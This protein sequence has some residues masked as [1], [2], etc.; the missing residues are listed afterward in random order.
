MDSLSISVLCII[1]YA[2][3]TH[4]R[5]SNASRSSSQTKPQ[6]EKGFGYPQTYFGPPCQ[7]P[8]FVPISKDIAPSATYALPP[9]SV[10]EPDFLETCKT[11]VKKLADHLTPERIRAIVF[12]FKRMVDQALPMCVAPSAHP[13]TPATSS[14]FRRPGTA[15]PLYPPARSS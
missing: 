14:F 9:P 8:D 13:L 6:P 12:E 4:I 11:L 2:I 5:D 1:P 7:E 10:S 3:A 15:D